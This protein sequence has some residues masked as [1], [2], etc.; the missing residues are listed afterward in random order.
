MH[1][2]KSQATAERP[3]IF[4]L[5]ECSCLTTASKQPEQSVQNILIAIFQKSNSESSIAG[6]NQS[7]PQHPWLTDSDQDTH[8]ALWR[9]VKQQHSLQS[10]RRH[11]NTLFQQVSSL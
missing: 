8:P 10:S 4:T 11:Q 1:M 5:N 9:L 7:L 6:N 3:A 2:N